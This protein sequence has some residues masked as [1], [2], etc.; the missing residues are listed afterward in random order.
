VD[1]ETVNLLK[2]LAELL[3]IRFITAEE[4]WS[5]R[6]NVQYISTGC[7]ALDDLLGGGIE[8]QAVTEF[9]GESSRIRSLL[10]HWLCFAVQ[11]TF[12]EEDPCAKAVYIDTEGAFRPE[13]IV[14]LAKDKGIDVKN[15]LKN[16]IY[17][18][19]HS[20]SSLILLIEDL[21]N[22]DFK[23]LLISSLDNVISYELSLG[24]SSLNILSNIA[25]LYL[26]S[27][28]I[29]FEKNAAVVF[30]FIREPRL[31]NI[32]F[33][34]FSKIVFFREEENKVVF[35]DSE[36]RSVICQIDGFQ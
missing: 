34:R 5:K 31:G 27:V 13:R 20:L 17:A 33:K 2:S 23:I 30:F 16:I 10:S 35:S 29:A 14:Q 11:L 8:T 7:K 4:Y 24:K 1:L 32:F 26:K 19:A 15:V 36:R 9:V 28:H 12:K 18:R 25:K 6:Q 22:K 3:G 21:F